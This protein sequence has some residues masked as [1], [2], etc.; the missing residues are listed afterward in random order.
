MYNQ[1]LNSIITH[2]I[3]I[4]NNNLI[5][6]GYRE[7][8]RRREEEIKHDEL[9]CLKCR[10]RTSHVEVDTWEGKFWECKV[11]GEKRK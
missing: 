4:Q 8:E 3:L 10:E 5:N 7:I 11:C 6:A 2:T 1:I 9:W